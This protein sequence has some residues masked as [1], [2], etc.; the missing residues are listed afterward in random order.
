M[1]ELPEV[2]TIRRGLAACLLGERLRSVKVLRPSVVVGSARRF[3]AA[4]KGRRLQ[5]FRRHGKLLIIDLSDGLSL[6]IHLRMTGQLLL[7][8]GP[9]LPAYT[10]V[11]FELAPGDPPPSRGAGDLARQMPFPSPP[12]RGAGVRGR[13]GAG[14]LAC[15]QC[16]SCPR[17]RRA[18]DPAPATPP[19]SSLVYADCRALGTLEV[20]PTADVP[21]HETLARM[22]PDALQPEALHHLTTLLD[23]RRAPIKTVLLDQSAIAGIGNIYASEILHA[24]RIAPDRP[25]NTLSSEER[26]RLRSAIRTILSA[27]VNS[28]GTTLVDG[29]YCDPLGAPG[30]YRQHL[31]VY[32]RAGKRCLR[33]GC[34]GAVARLVQQN[35][36]SFACRTCQR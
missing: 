13:R 4:L 2:E 28:G 25:A 9:E 11:V 22:G 36:S 19:A 7:P 14:I 1:P 31:R 10:R 6:L 15:D 30:A 21:R 18:A 16:R 32:G 33:R 35:R 26:R 29:L 23:R 24:A 5:A 8:R 3:A 27:A 20:R 17:L 34:P 12:G